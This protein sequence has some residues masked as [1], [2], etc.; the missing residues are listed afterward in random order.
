MRRIV[1]CFLF[2]NELQMLKFKLKELGDVVDHF[3]LVESRFTFTGN[4]KPLFYGENAELFAEYA[5][6]IVH[7]VHDH[8][9][10]ADT[11]DAWSNET[12]QRFYG[13]RGVAQLQLRDDDVV[14]LSDVDEIADKSTLSRIKQD[15]LAD[16]ISCLEQD[17]YY[18]NLTCKLREKWY[19]SKLVRFDAFR[20]YMGGTP[21]QFQTIVQ[22]T[23]N[24]GGKHIGHYS[25]TKRGGWHFSYFGGV[26]QIKLKLQNFS[27]TEL[28]HYG[29]VED[30]VLRQKIQSSRDLFDRETMCFEVIGVACNEYLPEHR[31]ML[32]DDAM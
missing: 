1:D 9:A 6:K 20:T 30:E 8:N 27:H 13:A 3:V 25:I 28:S 2:Y 29:D 15:G 24:P 21:A 19:R 22:P 32:L 17:M 16:P 5:D 18:Y 23:Y 11:G 14:I 4:E 12:E 26:S 10:A 31:A 7:V